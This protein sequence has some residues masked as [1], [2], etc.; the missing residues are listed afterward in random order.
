MSKMKDEYGL[1]NTR[2]EEGETRKDKEEKMK[3]GLGTTWG[4]RGKPE[5]T[6]KKR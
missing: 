4:K 2:G 6:K 3:T 1:G 5:R